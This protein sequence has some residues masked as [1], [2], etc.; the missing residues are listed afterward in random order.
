MTNAAQLEEFRI[1]YLGTRGA[2]KNL[3][4]LLK[5][6][7]AEQKPAFGKNANELR[8]RVQ[9]AFDERKGSLGAAAP[10]ATGPRL[11]LTEPGLPPQ[12]GREHVISQTTD[13]LIDVFGR[14]GFGVATGPEV[15]DEFHNFIALN[16]PEAHPA[17]DPLDNFYIDATPGS[18]HLLRSQTSTIQIRVME[19]TKPPVRVV[20]MGRVYRPDEH[21]A[22]HYSMFHQVEGL[23]V[24]RGV[25]MADLK[26]T[27]LQFAEA[28]F[29]AE[30]KVRLR[31]SFFPF[32]E[33]FPPSWT[34]AMNASRPMA[35]TGGVGRLRHGPS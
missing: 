8:Q 28:Y 25:S 5:E 17:R 22:T 1:K 19:K 2:V 3:M 23:Y 14:M 15:E 31:P 10:V 9:Q 16:I 6:V 33:E 27:L 21:D 29:G 11:D 18:A 24:D 20:A 13:E 26:T 12:L 32:T 7:P 30:A 35:A 4:G 34:Y